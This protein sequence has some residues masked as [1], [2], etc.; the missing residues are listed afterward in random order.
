MKT[1]ALILSVLLLASAFAGQVRA[2]APAVSKQEIQRDLDLYF[3]LIRQTVSEAGQQRDYINTRDLILA[4]QHKVQSS[5]DAGLVMVLK[6]VIQLTGKNIL[7]RPKFNVVIES[8]MMIAVAGSAQEYA[9]AL[10]SFKARF[11]S[12]R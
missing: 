3:A 9:Q 7:S 10:Q 11:P 5:N 8:L 4:L 2:E 1:L 12:A 6:D